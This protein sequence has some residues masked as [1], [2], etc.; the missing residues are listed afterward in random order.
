MGVFFDSAPTLTEKNLPDQ[1]GKVFIVT[2]ANS[3]VGELLAGI[4]YSKN[5]KV[6]V[7]ARSSE[8]GA[9]AIERI[10]ALYPDSRGALVF[11]HLDLGDLSTVKASADAFL[12]QETQLHVLWN[13]A[14]V[15]VPPQ[16]ST[17]KQGYELQ[18]GTNAVAPFLFTKLLTP[19]LT[20]TAKTAPVGSV[21]VVWVAS[22]AAALFS[23]KGGVVLDNLDY[24]Q[25]QTTWHKYGVSKAANILHAAEY[26]RRVASDNIVSVSLDPGNLKTPLYDNVP[27]YQRLFLKFVLKEPVYGAYTELFAGLSPDVQPKDSGRFIEPFGKIGSARADVETSRKSKEEGGNGVAEAFYDWTEKQVAPFA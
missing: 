27:A 23:P 16:G 1:A 11:L 6:Y 14:G 4:L 19:V 24:H 9:Q 21:R 10:K 7:A 3:G 8:K 25:D 15:M 13:N 22:S 18:L 12:R 5:A 20:S 2:G 26:A 17:T